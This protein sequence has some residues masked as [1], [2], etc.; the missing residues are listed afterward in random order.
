MNAESMDMDIEGREAEIIF[1]C[2]GMEQIVPVIQGTPTGVEDAYAKSIT[3]AFI[4]DDLQLTY[5]SDVK[6]LSI[7]SATGALVKVVELD[8]SGSDVVSMPMAKGVYMLSF[9]GAER[10]VRKVIK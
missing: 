4:M 6:K 5:P 1:E 7:Y 9:E 3:S 2:N 8:R 10:V